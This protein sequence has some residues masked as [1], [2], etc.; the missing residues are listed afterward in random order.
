MQHNNKFRYKRLGDGLDFTKIL[1]VATQGKP[2]PVKVTVDIT[3]ELKN[4]I[5]TFGGLFA[6]AIVVTALIRH[7]IKK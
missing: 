2:L 1:G 6:G 4:T 3:P 7:A 5:I